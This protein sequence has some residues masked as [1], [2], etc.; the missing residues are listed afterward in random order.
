MSQILLS[1]FAASMVT[2]VRSTP[3][4][5]AVYGHFMIWSLNSTTRERVYV[6]QNV[7]KDLCS[8]MY[9]SGVFLCHYNWRSGAAGKRHVNLQT[10]EEFLGRVNKL[11]AVTSLGIYFDQ[12][13]DVYVKNPIGMYEGRPAMPNFTT[14]FLRKVLA[15]DIQADAPVVLRYLNPAF[16]NGTY[17]S[18]PN[19]EY[20]TVYI[21]D[22]PI[23]INHPEFEGRFIEQMYMSLSAN[24]TESQIC[25]WEHGTHIASLIGGKTHGVSKKVRMVSVAVAGCGMDSR[26]SELIAGLD[27]ILTHLKTPAVVAVAVHADSGGAGEVVTYMV[28]KLQEAGA[29]VVAAGGNS[30]DN[31]CLY[32]PGSI[33][34]VVTLA[35][36]NMTSLSVGAPWESTNY[37]RCIDLWA[38]G[39]HIEAASATPGMTSIFS[40]TA[41]AMALAAGVAVEVLALNRTATPREVKHTLLSYSKNSVL[42]FDPP[43]TVKYFTQKALP[44]VNA[45]PVGC[46]T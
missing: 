36:V 21:V 17:V 44:H 19:S 15:A 33:P 30:A 42:A 27:W 41:Q 37:G 16:Y 28:N 13:K 5:Q 2:L 40:G 8:D 29:V 38:P 39:A 24:V 3:L 7:M 14:K 32:V 6:G 12:I 46:A 1:L 10:D 25:A 45:C 34:G 31:A 20:V 22:Q 35:A 9:D 18:T 23:N 26:V 11:P 4:L 43:E